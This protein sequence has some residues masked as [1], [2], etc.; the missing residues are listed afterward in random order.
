[1]KKLNEIEV[2]LLEHWEDVIKLNEVADGLEE[3]IA[4]TLQ[5]EVVSSLEE[6]DWW[7]KEFKTKTDKREVNVFKETWRLGKEEWDFVSIGVGVEESFLTDLTGTGEGRL[8]AYIWTDQLELLGSDKEKKFDK[9]FNT[10]SMKISTTFALKFK[11]YKDPGYPF[12]YYLPYSTNQWIEILKEGRFVETILEHFDIL[13]QFIGPI[14]RALAEVLGK[15][16]G[17]K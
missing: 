10:Y 17:K 6:K 13:A 5:K 8:N 1:M 11:V 4:S 15:K 14:D 7:S 2:Y 12:W 3:K 9:L 16:K